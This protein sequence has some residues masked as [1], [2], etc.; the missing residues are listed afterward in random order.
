[1]KEKPKFKKESSNLRTSKNVRK[2]KKRLFRL[3]P[4]GE[5]F[6]AI[7]G[8]MIMLGS[9]ITGI[10]LFSMIAWWAVLIAFLGIGLG[11][12]ICLI[13]GMIGIRRMDG[14]ASAVLGLIGVI[15]SLI[16]MAVWG[17]VGLI[18]WIINN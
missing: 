8:L 3:S 5:G 13:P 14:F 11:F 7:L 9:L 6:W 1:L 16:G 2:H 15:G 4:F 18:I 12:L 17:I 10:I